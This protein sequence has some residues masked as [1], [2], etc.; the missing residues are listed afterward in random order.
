[1]ENLSFDNDLALDDNGEPIEWAMPENDAAPITGDIAM[2]ESLM[3]L[4]GTPLG[5]G[6]NGLFCIIGDDVADI[7]YLEEWR[8]GEVG[9]LFMISERNLSSEPYQH[10]GEEEKMAAEDVI[11]HYL[12]HPWAY[13]GSGGSTLIYFGDRVDDFST[14]CELVLKRPAF[15][16]I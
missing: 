13:L 12:H 10:N 8:R 11:Y 15:F 5:Q 14:C 2:V 1:M 4:M 3:Q 7:R 6:E 9:E 16:K